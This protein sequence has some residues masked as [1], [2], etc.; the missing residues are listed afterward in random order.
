MD[1][2][3]LLLR[4]LAET[5]MRCVHM[6]HTQAT[7]NDEEIKLTWHPNIGHDLSVNS[8]RCKYQIIGIIL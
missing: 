2:Q 1:N 3:L 6:P 7:C 4:Q 8:A 5:I